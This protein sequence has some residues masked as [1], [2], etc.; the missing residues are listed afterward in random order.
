MG[1]DFFVTYQ[2]AGMADGF[3]LFCAGH[4]LWLAAGGAFAAVLIF[5]YMRCSRRGRRVILATLAVLLLADEC[6]KH[7]LLLYIGME[8]VDYLPLHLCSV[9][10]FVCMI[11]ALRPSKLCG[12]LLYSVCLPGT[13]AALL[14]PGWSSL[15]IGSFLSVH[16]FSYHI[17]LAVFPLLILAG[18]EHR[19][20]PKRLPQCTAILASLA[21]PIWFVNQ[22]YDTNFFFLNYAGEGNPLSWFSSKLGRPWYIVGFLIIAAALWT[23]M[24]LPFAVSGKR[25]NNCTS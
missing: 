14:F 2:T 1:K 20:S 12:E 22:R 15:P 7:A 10:M 13:V 18:G 9:G 11:Y 5:A 21:V 4:M 23:V 24:Y 25:K 3:E 16:S 19:P 17:L 6:A 8:R